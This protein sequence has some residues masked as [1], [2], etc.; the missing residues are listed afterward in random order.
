MQERARIC[1]WTPPRRPKAGVHDFL[2]PKI[3]KVSWLNRVSSF[4]LVLVVDQGT[5]WFSPGHDK[6]AAALLYAA[7]IASG[8]ANEGLGVWKGPCPR[9]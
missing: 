8:H 5:G 6:L 2:G 7:P 1:A 9:G 3:L 4:L